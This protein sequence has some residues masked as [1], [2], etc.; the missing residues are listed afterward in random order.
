[1]AAGDLLWYG[2]APVLHDKLN[3]ALPWLVGAAEQMRAGLQQQGR[4]V[5]M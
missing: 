1:M 2:T 5:F 4:A 3:T